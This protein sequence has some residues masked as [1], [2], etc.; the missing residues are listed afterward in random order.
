MN[1]LEV[2]KAGYFST[3][4]RWAAAAPAADSATSAREGLAAVQLLIE[5]QAEAVEGTVTRA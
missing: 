4:S 1:C 3:V 5:R 2:P